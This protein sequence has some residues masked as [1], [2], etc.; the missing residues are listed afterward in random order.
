MADQRAGC[1]LNGALTE[2]S[3]REP[4]GLFDPRHPA[5][6]DPPRPW[7]RFRRAMPV[8]CFIRLAVGPPTLNQ[9]AGS[10]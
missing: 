8:S 9:R 10:G 3:A 5:R 2:P 6:A 1:R 4:A 7:P